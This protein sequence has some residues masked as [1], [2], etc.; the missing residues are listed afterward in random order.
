MSNGAVAGSGAAAA[1]AIAQAIKASGAIVRVEPMDFMAL[2]ERAEKPLLVYC[3]SRFFYTSYQYLMGYKGLVFY[4][5]SRT[6]LDLPR[7]IEVVTAK[8]IWI[9]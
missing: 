8:K 2:L 4:T 7:N 6:P 9:P 1:A 3:E 5:K